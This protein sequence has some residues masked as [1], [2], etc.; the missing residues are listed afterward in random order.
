MDELNGLIERLHGGQQ[1][2]L[3]SFGPGFQGDL[4][5]Q[6]LKLTGAGDFFKPKTTLAHKQWA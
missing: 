5:Q 6:N 1:V 4:A 3:S 2:L